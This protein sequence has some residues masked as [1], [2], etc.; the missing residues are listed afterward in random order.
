M[1]RIEPWG[2]GD[3][4]LLRQCVGDPAMMRHLG[5]PEGPE[6]IAERQ[7]RYEQTGSRQFKIVD[8]AT[9]AGAGWVGYWEREWQ[10]QEIFEIGWAVIPA[11]QGRGMATSGTIE[12]VAVARAERARRFLHAYPS[13]GN[14]PSNAV[15][16]KAGFVLL[17]AFDFEY[18]EGNPIVC[19][20]WQ[21]DL[22]AD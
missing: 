14:A 21:I 17:G 10:A 7:S 6:K 8:A 5:G 19:N 22:F 3:V 18:P 13:V 12:A 15:C 1:V 4:E 16:R 20:D 2:T 9:G 11:F